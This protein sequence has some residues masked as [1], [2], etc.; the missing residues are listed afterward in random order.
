M[1]GGIVKEFGDVGLV[2]K[3]DKHFFYKICFF[4]FY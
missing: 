1:E 2:R 4:Y 3:Y